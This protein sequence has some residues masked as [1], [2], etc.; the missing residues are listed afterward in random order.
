MTLPRAP[1]IDTGDPIPDFTADSTHGPLRLHEVI[2]D[3]WALISTHPRAFTPVCSTE[4]VAEAR[5]SVEIHKRGIVTITIA[6]GSADDHRKWAEDLGNHAGVKIDFPIVADAD[7]SVGRTLG[8]LRINPRT[9]KEALTRTTFI[10]DPKGIVRWRITYPFSVGRG[11]NEIIRVLDSLQAGDRDDIFTPADWEA[12]D[13]VLV[14]GDVE[15]FSGDGYEAITQEQ[16]GDKFSDL[17]A[18]PYVKL[19]KKTEAAEA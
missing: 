19:Y 1:Y 3:K 7:R 11:T 15:L 12:G 16:A 4:I 5:R 14:I 10:I 13:P 6:E 8:T 2:K 9:D 18:L 17:A